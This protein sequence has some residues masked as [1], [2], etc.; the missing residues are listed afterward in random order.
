MRAHNVNVETTPQNQI[1][2]SPLF[3]G[4]LPVSQNEER[5]RQVFVLERVLE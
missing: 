4:V 1:L 2:E 5:E 3:A